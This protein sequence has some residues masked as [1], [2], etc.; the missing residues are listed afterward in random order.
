MQSNIFAILAA[1]LHLGNIKFAKGSGDEIKV[2]NLDGTI[3]IIIE[4]K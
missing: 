3:I 2:V 1:I 4:N